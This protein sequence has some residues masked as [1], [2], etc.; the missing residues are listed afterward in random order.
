MIFAP[1]QQLQNSTLLHIYIQSL[2]PK[3]HFLTSKM[4]SNADAKVEAGSKVKIV[5]KVKPR[6][7][8]I[9]SKDSELSEAIHWLITELPELTNHCEAKTKRV[10]D[11]LERLGHS[12]YPHS[13]AGS[14][15]TLDVLYTASA[16]YSKKTTMHYHT[17]T[18]ISAAVSLIDLHKA[19]K[20]RTAALQSHAQSQSSA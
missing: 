19:Q 12:K 13:K 5:L 6:S 1:S 4:I 15:E 9:Y 14:C 10:T 7:S 8:T 18:I 2:T 20:G 17:S 16:K 3:P 11:V